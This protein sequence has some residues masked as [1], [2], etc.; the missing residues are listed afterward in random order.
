MA[1]KKIDLVEKYFRRLFHTTAILAKTEIVFVE[2]Q[3][4]ETKV[5]FAADVGNHAKYVFKGDKYAYITN[6]E[7]PF[8]EIYQDMSGKLLYNIPN[9]LML[10]PSAVQNALKEYFGVVWETT[11]PEY[12]DSQMDWKFEHWPGFHR[13]NMYQMHIHGC[14]F[15][16]KNGLKPRA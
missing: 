13:Y 5:V 3:P 1:K 12:L 8:M 2:E 16:R 7:S 11:L 15:D 9:H 10:D 6:P 14:K 4:R